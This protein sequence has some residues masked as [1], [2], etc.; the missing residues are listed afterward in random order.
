[1]TMEMSHTKATWGLP[2]L[3][4]P[5]LRWLYLGKVLRGEQLGFRATAPPQL[6]PSD[7]VDLDDARQRLQAEVELVQNPSTEFL[8]AHPVFGA[9]FAAEQWRGMHLWHAAHHLSFLIP[10]AAPEAMQSDER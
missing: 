1:K 4:R 6:A 5:L 10:T 7:D 3:V 9:P 2:R 8:P